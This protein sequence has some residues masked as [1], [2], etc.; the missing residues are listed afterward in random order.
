MLFADPPLEQRPISRQTLRRGTSEGTRMGSE[1][2]AASWRRE[3]GQK[4]P[5]PDPKRWGSSTAELSWKTVAT[6]AVE[7]ARSLARPEGTNTTVI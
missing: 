5:E 4:N 7:A 2:S 3:E 6:R 1:N